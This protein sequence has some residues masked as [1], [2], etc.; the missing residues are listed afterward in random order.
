MPHEDNSNIL[1]IKIFI[2]TLAIGLSVVL[3]SCSD[4]S[5]PW[6]SRIRAPRRFSEIILP[7]PTMCFSN[8]ARVWDV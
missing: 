1:L 6:P 4:R 7:S 8:T 2:K 3:L 5:A